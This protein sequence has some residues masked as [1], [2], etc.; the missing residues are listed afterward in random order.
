M[1]AVMP[2]ALLGYWAWGGENTWASI[3]RLPDWAIVAALGCSLANYVLRS[4]RWR[5]LVL[6]ADSR[7][8]P[9]RG[10]AIYLAGLGLT[11]SPGKVG[12]LVRGWLTAPWGI[13]WPPIALAFVAERGMDIVVVALMAICFGIGGFV[14]APWPVVVII[15]ATVSTGLMCVRIPSVQ[16]WI[17]SFLRRLPVLRRLSTDELQSPLDHVLSTTSLSQNALLSAL[18]WVVQGCGFMLLSLSLEPLTPWASLLAIFLVAMLAGAASGLPGGLGATEA[19]LA[20]GLTFLGLNSADSIA[21]SLVF[22]LTSLWFATVLGLFV[23]WL[24][25]LQWACKFTSPT[26]TEPM[27][28][29]QQQTQAC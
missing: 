2:I 1:C 12:E 3:G 18:A 5:N 11:A 4:A 28:E 10:G 27:L 20:G 14:H 7:L 19:G 25:P 29:S 13:R 23:F 9:W 15:L 16:R 24:G 21:I 6:H 22:R 8:G 26:L 17:I